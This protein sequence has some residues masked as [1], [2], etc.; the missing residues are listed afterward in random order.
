[1]K[2]ISTVYYGENRELVSKWDLGFME[3]FRKE[4]GR[5]Y[6]RLKCGLSKGTSDI[7]ASI[8]EWFSETTSYL[9]LHM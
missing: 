5:S 6:D 8:R 4:P 2:K 9:G 1:M 3:G 7:K